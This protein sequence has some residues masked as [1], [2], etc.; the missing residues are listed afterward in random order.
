MVRILR[1]NY[2]F[3]TTLS[4]EVRS[5]KLR[6]RRIFHGTGRPCTHMAVT[7]ARSSGN[8]EIAVSTLK[9]TLTLTAKSTQG[10]YLT[11]LP[12][13]VLPHCVSTDANSWQSISFVFLYLA[14]P[15]LISFVSHLKS[16]RDGRAQRDISHRMKIGCA[17]I[18]EMSDTNTN[19]F[20]IDS[21]TNF[22]CASSLCA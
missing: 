14:V 8:A 9:K 3:F 4:H 2:A 10:T 18:Q 12:R 22:P 16:W 19:T 21:V 13:L 6:L 15:S 1:Y 17:K 5:V 20:R 11:F 7:H